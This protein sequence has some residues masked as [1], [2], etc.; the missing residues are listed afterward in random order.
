MTAPNPE[1]TEEPYYL[2][3]TD[4]IFSFPNLVVRG[5]ARATE[6][7]SI[8]SGLLGGIFGD[9]LDLIQSDFYGIVRVELFPA[10]QR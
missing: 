10:V 1:V 9:N 8:A 7:G 5:V 4:G 6:L 3:F 2:N